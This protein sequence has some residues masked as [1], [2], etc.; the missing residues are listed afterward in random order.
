MRKSFLIRNALAS[1]AALSAAAWLVSASPD[2]QSRP[3]FLSDDPMSREP[4][5]QDASKVQE[6]DIGLIADLTFNL[7]AKPGDPMPDVRAQNINTIDEVPDSSWFNNRIYTKPITVEDITRGPNVPDP[8]APGKWTIIRAKTAGTAPGFTVRDEKGNV[9]FLSMDAHGRPI[10]ATAAIAVATRLFWAL[11][12]H[13][14]EAHLVTMRPEQLVIGE[15]VTVPSHGRRRRY[16]QKDVDDVFKR[17]AQNADGS[18]R[19]MAAR[20]LPGRVVG[21]FRYFGT[22]PDDPN[23]VVPHEHRRELRAL[24]VFGG[25]TNLVDMKA[26]N[27]LDTIVTEGGQSRV[28]HYLQDVGSTFGTGSVGPRAGDEG[29]EYVYEHGPFVKRLFTLGFYI[30]PWQTLDFVDSPQVGH[31]TA[32]AYEPEKWKPRVPVAA[33]LRIRADDELWAALRVTSFTD[34]L[35]RAAVKTGEFTDP[36]A[37]K[38]LG[39]VLIQRRDTIGRVYF[40]KVNPLTRFALDASGVLTF[41]NPA[42]R[43]RLADAP[44]GGYQ[45]VWARF[46]NATGTTQALGAGSTSG[47]S[48]EARFQ[49]P[50]DLP[51]APGS[52]VKVS[53]TA[54]DPPHIM[55]T[56]PVDAYFRR[57]AGGWQLVGVDRLPTAAAPAT[58]SPAKR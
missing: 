18:Y 13:V 38:L 35:I 26:G 25:W 34:E 17:A 43:T 22:R 29:H 41:D 57:T 37:E 49:A 19:V 44:K 39:D 58:A 55:W 33:L 50:G 40:G 32:E 2:A 3:K 20:G 28:R 54:V 8:P 48:R 12:Y 56:K 1:A 46:D 7:F 30:Q 21:G 42:V 51:T 11:G 14:P 16:R 10:V 45:A 31:F 36:A 52:F 27:T 6:W 23:D 53:V 15:D 4:E 9:W 24:Q 5:T 47:T